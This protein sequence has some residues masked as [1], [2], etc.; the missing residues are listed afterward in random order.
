ML[1]SRDLTI[2]YVEDDKNLRKEMHEVLNDLFSYVILAEDGKDGLEKLL[3]YK[4]ESGEYPDIVMTDISMP[5][6]NGI[7]MSKKIMEH[8][9]EQL[10]IVLSADNES[11]CLL[12]LI[13]MGIEHYLIKPIGANQLVQTLQRA[14][15]KSNDRKMELGYIKELEQLAYNDP[16]TGIANRRRLFEKS[17]TLFQE[18]RSRH[19]PVQLFMMDIDKFKEIND[20]FGHAVGD[21]VIR[22]FVAIV[23]N[24]LG[25]NDCFARVGGDEFILLMHR[26]QE[27]DLHIMKKI[28]ENISETHSLLGNQVNFSVSMG[29]TEIEKF[30]KD[31]DTV[32][33]RA[34]ISLYSEKRAKRQQAYI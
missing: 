9:S 27:K 13:N 20:T 2:L 7:E 5:R 23:K 16:L 34:D 26:S 11:H 29:M 32:I 22:I 3:S 30:D 18:N 15:K 14:V 17:Q 24:E 19:I 28:Q 12:E 6:S 33:K 4:E 21:E 31:I 25:E 1:Q 10:I 8:H